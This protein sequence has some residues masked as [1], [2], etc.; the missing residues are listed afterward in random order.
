MISLKTKRMLLFRGLGFGL[1][2]CFHV[3]PRSVPHAF[4]FVLY[5]CV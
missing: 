3:K 2:A 4:R 5:A 1:T